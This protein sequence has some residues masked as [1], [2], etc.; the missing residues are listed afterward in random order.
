[1]DALVRER[2]D[3]GSKGRNLEMTKQME[4]GR[5][6]D[7]LVAERVYN[8]RWI[9]SEDWDYSILVDPVTYEY[10]LTQPGISPGKDWPSAYE[11]YEDAKLAGSQS[12]PYYSTD[13]AA[14]W[15]VAEKLR[16]WVIPY[17]DDPVGWCAGIPESLSAK[18]YVANMYG[19]DEIGT[20]DGRLTL[21]R[22]ATAPLAIC[23]AALALS[24]SP[25]G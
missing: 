17:T 20:V 2:S 23:L 18:S 12:L 25:R 22:A 16:L 7:A 5:L 21:A 15:Q 14:A 10:Q 13:I 1:M 24:G 8:W 11:E 4:A 6:L 3:G 9:T 19:P